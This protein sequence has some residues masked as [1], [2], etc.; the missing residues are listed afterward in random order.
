MLIFM[1]KNGVKVLS[2][3][4]NSVKINNELKIERE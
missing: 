1:K 3:C 2:I 4:G